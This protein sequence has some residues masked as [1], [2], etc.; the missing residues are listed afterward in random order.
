MKNPLQ[1]GECPICFED[2]ILITTPCKHRFCEECI[3][4]ALE[5]KKSCP[6]CCRYLNA[7][8]GYEGVEFSRVIV[9]TGDD[10]NTRE[11]DNLNVCDS[12]WTLVGLACILYLALRLYPKWQG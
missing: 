8:R 2:K 1:D 10:L 11:N 3:W 9:T 7:T 6:M 12:L 5:R 4:N